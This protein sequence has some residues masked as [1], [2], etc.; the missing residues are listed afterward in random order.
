MGS[1]VNRVIIN[2]PIL[3]LSCLPLQAARKL[4]KKVLHVLMI[5]WRPWKSAKN[6]CRIWSILRML[7]QRNS[8]REF[9]TPTRWIRLSKRFSRSFGTISTLENAL[10]ARS[11]SKPFARKDFRSSS[12]RKMFIKKTHKKATR[13]RKT[14]MTPQKMIKMNLASPSIRLSWTKSILILLRSRNT[15]ADSGRR[16]KSSSTSYS[17]PSKP[18]RR[19]SRTQRKVTIKGIFRFKFYLLWCKLL[20][21]D[22]SYFF[23]WFAGFLIRRNDY[24]MFFIEV[25][26]VTPNRFRPENK[27]GE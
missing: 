7:I 6:S 15:C 20:M 10:I 26:P 12:S 18:M 8:L 17:V 5:A 23:A 27:L 9:P 11:T 13:I 24:N 14:T 16:R 21:F 22:L 2:P 19:F 1:V 4:S 25:I 3:K